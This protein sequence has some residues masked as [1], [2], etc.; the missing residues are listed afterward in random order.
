MNRS[1]WREQGLRVVEQKWLPREE[2]RPLAPQEV[3]VAPVL[4]GE[5]PTRDTEEPFRPR[6]VLSWNREVPCHC[7]LRP[8]LPFW[9]DME[10]ELK[11]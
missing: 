1:L 4:P 2:P 8:P 5:C 10:E 7:L 6:L 11:A 9:T 3:A